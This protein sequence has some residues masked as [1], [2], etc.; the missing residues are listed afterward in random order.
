M[1]RSW[2]AIK[3]KKEKRERERK[4]CWIF[5]NYHPCCVFFLFFFFFCLYKAAHVANG[6][7]QAGVESEGQLLAYTTATATP[8]LNH[9]FNLY[10][11]SWK[12]WILN[13][14][15]QARDQTGTSTE[16]SWNINPLCHS[17]NS[18]GYFVKELFWF[19]SSS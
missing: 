1:H 2:V 19:T 10:H 17:R 15:C 5:L 12:H 9:I 16:T 11:S 14:L 7:S 3:A 18:Q 4:G 8:D 13:P 6:S